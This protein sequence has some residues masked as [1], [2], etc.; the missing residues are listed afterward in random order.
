VTGVQTCA[1]PIYLMPS[2]TEQELAVRL[3]MTNRLLWRE[4]TATRAF[5]LVNPLLTD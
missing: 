1:L 2:R 4:N 5:D 3:V